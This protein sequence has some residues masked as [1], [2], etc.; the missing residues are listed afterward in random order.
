MKELRGNFLVHARNL[1]TEQGLAVAVIDAPSDRQNFPH[2]AKTVLK[3][4]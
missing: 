1:F 4:T 2:P 3:L